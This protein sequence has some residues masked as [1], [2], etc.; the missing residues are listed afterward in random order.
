MSADP[1][2][3]IAGTVALGRGE[4]AAY[5]VLR[6]PLALLE[7]PLFVLLPAL[8]VERTGLALS[9]V[10][11]LLF[12]TRL[13]DAVFDPAIGAWIDRSPPHWSYRRWIAFALPV[14]ALG[15]AALFHPPSPAAAAWWLAIASTVTYLAYSVV[16]I[17]YQSWGAVIA[18]DPAARVRVTAVREAF[19]VAG[20]MVSAS[21]L[22]PATADWLV[23][24]FAVAAAAG[25]AAMLHAPD[26]PPRMPTERAASGIGL[27][28]RQVG[29]STSFRWLLAVFVLNGIAT[30]IPA[31][32]VIFFVRDVLDAPALTPLF[33]L[34]YFAAGAVG[35]PVWVHL[36]RRFNVRNAWLIGMSL[37]VSAFVFTLGLGPGDTVQFGIVC[38]ATGLA[39]GADLALP[40]ALLAG[41]VAAEPRTSAREPAYFGVW[42]LATKLNLAA[43][44]GIALPVLQAAGYT[45]G[46]GGAPPLALTLAYAA[47]PSAL[48]LAAGA[49]LLVAPL[50]DEAR[51]EPTT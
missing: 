5:G 17:A 11:L 30:A 12:A 21:L 13:I 25:A 9:V 40:P 48:K 39:L 23:V 2:R 34:V 4:L 46:A 29:N 44:A 32:L 43:A 47:L 33:L 31:T 26:A 42:N 6:A 20:V 51:T 19:G 7:L 37:A 18:T 22:T 24:L 15:F 50:P 27:M 35:M 36:S 41:V 38:A 16:S 45:P 10:G 3:T 28:W 8:Y 49:V 14:L 1:S